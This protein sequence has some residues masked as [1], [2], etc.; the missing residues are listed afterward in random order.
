MPTMFANFVCDHF[1]LDLNMFGHCLGQQRPRRDQHL[2]KEGIYIFL[3]SHRLLNDVNF[4]P[5]NVRGEKMRERLGVKSKMAL[6]YDLW[7]PNFAPLNCFGL[8][9]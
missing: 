9:D 6:V 8:G 1:K 7:K 5:Y 4:T 3:Y 2:E